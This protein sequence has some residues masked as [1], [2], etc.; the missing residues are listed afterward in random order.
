MP[1][2]VLAGNDHFHPR[3][4]AEEIADLAPHAELI[5][6]WAGPERHHP[7]AER[8]RQFLLDHTPPD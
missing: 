7:T 8:V 1:L 2:L 4:V 5:V 3:A 6:D